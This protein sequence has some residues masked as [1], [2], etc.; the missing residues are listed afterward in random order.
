MLDFVLCGALLPGCVAQKDYDALQRQLDDTTTRLGQ[1]EDARQQLA[2]TLRAKLDEAKAHDEEL[3]A[4]IEALGKELA[5]AEVERIEMEGRLATI[6]E[7][8][9]QLEASI[10][11]MQEALAELRKRRA[12]AERRI[13]A[14]H[15]L[16]ER[17]RSLID[18]GQLSVK[19][20][21]GR[22]I[23]EM[24]T[25]VLFASGSAKLSPEGERAVSD[26]TAILAAI[27]ERR[28][29]VEGHTDNVPISNKTYPSNWEL[30]AARALV[31]VQA[32]VDAGL[33]AQRVSA[34]SFSE[35][36]PTATNDTAAGK[37]KNRRIEIV[38]LPNLD[39]LPGAEELRRIAG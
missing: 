39:D 29:Q 22:M 4:Q 25:D 2:D 28:Y 15:D 24:Q 21:D 34:A 9:G 3:R 8:K 33:D 37:A 1:A 10:T 13:A 30:A 11:E 31:V 17:F 19:I 16:L 36:H 12:A 6:L 26:V 18:A 14:Y 27:P 5:Q 23:V 35:Y 32:M 38:V 7:D 20:V